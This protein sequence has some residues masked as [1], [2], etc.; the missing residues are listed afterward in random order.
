MSTRPEALNEIS[1]EDILNPR[2]IYFYRQ[3]E[4]VDDPGVF[5]QKKYKILPT[6]DSLFKRLRE[7]IAQLVT[8]FD[9]IAKWSHPVAAERPELS[10]AIFV[11]AMPQ[12]LDI[13]WP[14]VTDIISTCLNLDREEVAESWYPDEKLD[15]LTAIFKANRLDHLLKKLLAM[16]TAYL[17]GRGT[18]IAASLTNNTSSPQESGQETL[19]P[20][21]PTSGKSGSTATKRKQ[22]ITS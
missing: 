2:P 3:V 11:P 1:D 10:I 18:E 16:S 8:L 19:T 22:N 9:G 6:P 12:V 14:N 13:L 15:A 5:I 20:S 7:Q 21:Q 4:N 17:P